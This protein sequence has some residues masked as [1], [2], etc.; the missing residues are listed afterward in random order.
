MAQL[1]ERQMKAAV[2]LGSALVEIVF[3]LSLYQTVFSVLK[4]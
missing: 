2:F 3:E 1:R 4:S